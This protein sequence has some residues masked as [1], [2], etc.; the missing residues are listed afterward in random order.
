M[1]ITK[2]SH[3]HH[4]DCSSPSQKSYPVTCTPSSMFLRLSSSFQ[5]GCPLCCYTT[6]VMPYTIQRS[7]CVTNGHYCGTF[8]VQWPL[9]SSRTHRVPQADTQLHCVGTVCSNL[10]VPHP[11][12]YTK[13]VWRLW[14]GSWCNT[15]RSVVG[16]RTSLLC[17]RL[18]LFLVK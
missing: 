12:Y 5:E 13:D 17:A 18:L 2:S 8:M 11:C 14:W 10:A 6:V 9:W 15:T 1:N 16:R 4:L 3:I 7:L